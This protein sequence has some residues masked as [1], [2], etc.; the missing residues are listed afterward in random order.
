MKPPRDLKTVLLQQARQDNNHTAVQMLHMEKEVGLI[1]YHGVVPY[2]QQQEWSWMKRL[3]PS[4]GSSGFSS[5]SS[6][7]RDWRTNSSLTQSQSSPENNTKVAQVAF[8]ITSRMK[9]ELMDDLGYTEEQVRSM[10]PLVAGLVLDERVAPGEYESRM[11]QLVQEAEER[12]AKDRAA[13]TAASSSSSSATETVATTYPSTMSNEVGTEA[14]SSPQQEE[15]SLLLTTENDAS[16][17]TTTTSTAATMS[18]L[19]TA[20]SAA[21]ANMSS[22]K[23]IWYQVMEETTNSNPSTIHIVGLY[24]SQ[25]EAEECRALKQDM[26]EREIRGRGEADNE[27]PSICIPRFTVEETR[28]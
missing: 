9:M 15:P 23:E 4:A 28:R 7:S 24:R 22:P 26:A 20:S 17:S 21:T 19:T 12:L 27:D 10:T 5:S 11:P 13:K 14:T 8:M 6:S 16:R 3:L 1:R 2:L 25:K 18:R